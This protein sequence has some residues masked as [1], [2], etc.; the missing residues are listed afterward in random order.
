LAAALA[1]EVALLRAAT[2]LMAK[3]LKLVRAAPLAAALAR[4]VALLMAALLGEAL[5]IEATLLRAT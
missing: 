3:M 5:A 4:E 2:L 1:R